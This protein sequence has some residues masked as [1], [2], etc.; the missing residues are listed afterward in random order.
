ME[1]R[2]VGQDAKIAADL[3][4]DVGDRPAA[5]LGGDLRRGGHAGETG[6]SCAGE[7]RGRRLGAR[8]GLGVS[9]GSH[10][11]GRCGQC[12]EFFVQ[13][14]AM[15]KELHFQRG[16]ELEAAGDAREDQR[17]IAAAEQARGEIGAA[18][19]AE[20]AGEFLAV[21]DEFADEVEEAAEVAGLGGVR[22]SRVGLVGWKG[23]GGRGGHEHNKNTRQRWVSRNFFTARWLSAK[24]GGG[25]FAR[26]SQ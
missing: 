3:G 19:R 22:A 13:A 2:M 15:L 12:G 5:D 18:V 14:V 7:A 16:S 23:C 24:A 26:G 21:V 9:P 10:A 11:V 4:E 25:C 6:R 20:G 17:D 1:Q 8:P